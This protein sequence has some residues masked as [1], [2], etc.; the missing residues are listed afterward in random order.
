MIQPTTRE[1]EALEQYAARLS[2]QGYRVVREPDARD[3]P[4]F[5]SDFRPHAIALGEPPDPN[6]VVEV[7]AKGDP[8]AVARVRALKALLDGHADWRLDIVYAGPAT[9]SKIPV[10][11]PREIRRTLTMSQQLSTIEPRA[12]L[13]LAWSALEAALR[14]L[15]P[16]YAARPLVSLALVEIAAREGHILPVQADRLRAIAALRNR[17][18]HGDLGTPVTV[19]DVDEVRLL[20]DALLSQAAE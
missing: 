18:A 7:I 1:A 9:A 12:A 5:L 4:S 15:E 11:D 2:S 16:E 10:V 8:D 20:A 6:F 13:L 17:L 19:D 3:L 14:P